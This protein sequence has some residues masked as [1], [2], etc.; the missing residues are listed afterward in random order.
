MAWVTMDDRFPEN[1]KVA[2]LTAHAFRLHVTAICHSN[3]NLTDGRV[4]PASLRVLLTS[5]SATTKHVAEL[6]SA[7]LWNAIDDGHEIH[8]Y[9][10][11]N[12]SRSTIEQQRATAAE[13]KRR[14]REREDTDLNV[15]RDNHRDSSHKS[16][17][18]TPL[19]TRDGTRESRTP[20]PHHTNTTPQRFI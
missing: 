17:N 1:E 20:P 3:R 7:G 13:R 6:V 9:L 10:A 11:W 12:K 5:S 18:V 15:T 16:P 4:S 14:Q 2:P 8:D 19:V